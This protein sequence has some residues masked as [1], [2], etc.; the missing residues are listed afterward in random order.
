MARQN[1]YWVGDRFVETDTAVKTG[2]E[3]LV[4]A[5]KDPART[6][7][8]VNTR[9]ERTIIDKNQSVDVERFERFE[10]LPSFIYG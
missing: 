3:I 1:G 4:E 7:V 2:R 10:D 8:A 6:V 5:G 9:G